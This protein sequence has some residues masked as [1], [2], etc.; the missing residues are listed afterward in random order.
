MNNEISLDVEIYDVLEVHASLTGLT[1]SESIDR[2]LSAHL[3]E[4]HEVL[5]LAGDHPEL[6]DEAANLIVSYGPESIDDGI[7]RIA[8]AHYLTLSQQFE[9]QMKEG[10]GAQLTLHCSSLPPATVTSQGN[11]F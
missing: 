6:R 8:P 2:L 3:G 7:K 1:V 9:R 11:L 4:L 10:G 5:A